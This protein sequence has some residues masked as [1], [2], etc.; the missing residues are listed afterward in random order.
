MNII[1][2]HMIQTICIGSILV[3]SGCTSIGVNSYATFEPSMVPE[4]F[5]NGPMTAHGIV[6]DRKGAVIRYFNAD[7]KG[8]VQGD[9]ITLD[10]D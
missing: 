1:K 6:K 9:T 8:S 4:K 3:L 2:K 10:E 7:I 5:F